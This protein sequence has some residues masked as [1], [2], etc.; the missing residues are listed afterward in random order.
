MTPI[1]IACAYGHV[2]LVKFLL[3]KGAKLLLRDKYGRSP[4]AMAARNGNV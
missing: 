4:C 3:E 1:S 2:E